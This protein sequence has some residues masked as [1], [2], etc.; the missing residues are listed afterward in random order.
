LLKSENTKSVKVAY[1]AFQDGVTP[2][3]LLSDVYWRNNQYHAYADN[4]EY[5]EKP[6][7]NRDSEGNITSYRVKTDMPIF[8]NKA[9][10]RLVLDYE[11]Q[12]NPDKIVRYLN[13]KAN[14]LIDNRG[15]KFT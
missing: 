9:G 12:V 1:L 11:D 14:V 8:K 3:M 6:E 10:K 4:E 15:D 13:I 5:K 2:D 7:I